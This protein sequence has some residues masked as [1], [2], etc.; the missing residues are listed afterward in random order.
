MDDAN[1][2]LAALY[3]RRGFVSMHELS[4]LLDEPQN[5]PR[6][7]AE[8]EHRGCRCD[9]EPARGLRISDPMRL[10]AYLIE[11]GLDTRMIGRSVVCFDQVDSTNDVVL[12]AA[13]SPATGGLVV[14]AESQRL[15]RGRRGSKWIS[16]PSVGLLFS[17]LLV[18]GPDILGHEPLTI[19]AGLATAEGI[20]EHSSSRCDLKWPNDVRIDGSKVAGVL[21]ESRR[22]GDVRATAIG[23]GVNVFASPPAEAVNRP[24]THVALHNTSV[25]RVELLQS[26]LRRLDYWRGEIIANRYDALHEAWLGRC[27]ML[28]QRVRILS[29][30]VEHVGRVVDISPLEGLVLAGDSGIHVQLPA[31]LSTVL[32]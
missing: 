24:A 27:G 22:D 11:R 29:G 16:P 9:R 23:I 12:A 13:G 8:L 5:L 4:G 17:T 10:D 3:D 1:V 19:A 2:I 25:R 15:G 20:E 31:A 26:I 14:T 6:A 18:D 7:L 21:I 28:H 30:G 32:E